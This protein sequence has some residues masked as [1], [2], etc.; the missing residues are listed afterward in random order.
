MAALSLEELSLGAGG[1]ALPVILSVITSSA[2]AM[3]LAAH[4]DTLQLAGNLFAG[5]YI[6]A[7][8]PDFVIINMSDTPFFPAVSIS[9]VSS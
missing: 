2:I 7:S 5:Q 8:L 4:Q 9:K 6:C 1:G 3:D